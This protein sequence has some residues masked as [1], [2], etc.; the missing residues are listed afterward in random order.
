[1]KLLETDLQSEA[2]VSGPLDEQS[3]RLVASL[4]TLF[5]RMML[6]PQSADRPSFEVTKEEVR[7]MIVLS[8][9]SEVTMSD[10][11][12]ALAVPL[13]TATHT[14]DKLVAKDLAVRTRSEQDRRLVLVAMSENGRKFQEA[15]RAGHRITARSWLGPLSPGERELFLELMAKITRLASFRK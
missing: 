8:Q 5:H 3:K 12:E 4:E 13:S 6:S 14:V 2:S 7:A 1:M 11:A 9:R 15:M 10:L